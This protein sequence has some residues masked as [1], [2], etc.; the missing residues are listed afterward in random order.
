MN[1]YGCTLANRP[2]STIGLKSCFIN[3]ATTE[4]ERFEEEL[5]KGS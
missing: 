1:T 3:E 5:E 4:G 2:L